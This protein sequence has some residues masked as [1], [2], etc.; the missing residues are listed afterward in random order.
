[1]FFGALEAR[2]PDGYFGGAD[3]RVLLFGELNELT[4]MLHKIR[5][6]DSHGYIECY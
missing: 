4:L 3:D 6:V 2:G 5:L 1:M